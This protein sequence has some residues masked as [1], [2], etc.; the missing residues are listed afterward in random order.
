MPRRGTDRL[1]DLVALLLIWIGV[2]V[3]IVSAVLGL[4]EHARQT[5]R[6]RIEVA[7]ARDT[8]C[9]APGRTRAPD[10]TLA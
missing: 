10:A 8:R 7:P 9:S 5:E 1:E 3:L 4:A 6:S 2:G